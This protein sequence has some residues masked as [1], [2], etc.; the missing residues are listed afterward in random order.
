MFKN[1][2][3]LVIYTFLFIITSCASKDDDM[4]ME[5][6][7]PE[8]IIELVAEGNNL[9]FD[10]IAIN[11][12]ATKKLTVK[13]TG[14]SSLKI[15]NIEIP[16][17]FSLDWSSGT[18]ASQASQEINVTFA[19]TDIKEY[20]GNIIF[21]SNAKKA[22]E[23]ILSS[24]RGLSDVYEGDISLASD[25]EIENFSS[26]GFTKIN[27]ELCLGLCD[28]IVFPDEITSLLP[29]SRIT[30]VSNFTLKLNSGL[31]DLKGIEQLVVSEN[32]VIWSVSGIKN[33]DELA[34]NEKLTGSIV[35]YDNENLENVDGLANIS[36]VRT[37]QVS[38]NKKL[39]NIDGL[40]NIARTEGRV[41][42]SHN[43]ILANINGLSNLRRVAGTFI[44][45][46]CP[47]IENLDVLNKLEVIGERLSIID[48]PLITNLDGLRNVASV[49]TAI[50]LHR[51]FNLY[52][53]CNVLTILNNT[54]SIFISYNRYNNLSQILNEECSKEVPPN[55]YNGDILLQN[56]EEIQFFIDLGYDTIDG[57]LS[58][59]EDDRVDKE[60]ISL[61]NL[62]QIKQVTQSFSITH[63][64]ISSLMGFEG[65]ENLGGIFLI[66]NN[67]NLVDY[68]AISS[69]FENGYAP[70][71]NRYRVE[72]NGFNPT[73]NEL[74]S[75]TCN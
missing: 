14:N 65:L 46:N 62:S 51:N 39:T 56:D 42:I 26:K 33:I 47:L 6:I 10:P 9:S 11:F 67:Q 8:A 69:L 73:E 35:I 32:I 5:T 28:G 22:T 34:V 17:G 52:N 4:P 16:D 27:G 21:T 12:T 48:L 37:L 24:G 74:S 70:G 55:I 75:G 64:H 36:E 68:C 66:Y 45:N 71:P 13:N 23:N 43:D 53:F 58:I 49:G 29:L 25:T 40:S 50:D 44:I 2:I 54:S 57:S 1:L 72:E 15:S 41:D 3:S 61:E 31:T 60:I 20:M 19:P 38:R 63:T 59:T 30:E 18:I 7:A